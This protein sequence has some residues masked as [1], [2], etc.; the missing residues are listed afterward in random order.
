MKDI[1]FVA[2][3]KSLIKFWSFDGVFCLTVNSVR[4]DSKMFIK[5]R[6][7]QRGFFHFF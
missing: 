2:T 5:I 4:D 7:A 3:T 1:C 6:E